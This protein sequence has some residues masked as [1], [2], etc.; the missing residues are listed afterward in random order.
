[1]LLIVHYL[2]LFW[3]TRFQKVIKEHCG[4]KKNFWFVC[5]TGRLLPKWCGS[6]STL[7]SLHPSVL[8][9]EAS[10]GRHESGS[11]IS[12]R[13][14]LR[15]KCSDVNVVSGRQN[16]GA[17]SLGSPWAVSTSCTGSFLCAHWVKNLKLPIMTLCAI[18]AHFSQAVSG[19][20]DTLN[21]SKD[22]CPP[23]HVFKRVG[24]KLCITGRVQ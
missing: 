22:T 4:G 10:G 8:V 21:L 6:M 18:T 2:G 5:F 15:T 23:V 12:S 13:H 11:C 19:G 3:N 24:S 20:P 14:F 16:R 1:M 9:H 17:R 7:G